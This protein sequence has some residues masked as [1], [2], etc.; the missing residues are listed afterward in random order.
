MRKK[1]VPRL[2][3][4]LFI[5]LFL[6][7]ETFADVNWLP[8]KE[9]DKVILIRHALAPGSGDPEGFNLKDCST[10]RN[11]DQVGIN[12][13]KKI[14][15]LFKKNNISIDQVLSSQWCR[16]KD[17]AKYAFK[18]YKEFSPLNST[19]QSPYKKKAEQQI[20]ELKN[21]VK[22]WNGNGK[23]LVLITHYIVITEVTDA[24]P[25]SGEIVITDKNFN[26]LTTIQTN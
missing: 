8:A 20:K 7:K 26:V 1:L 25:R 17:T 10:Q 23:N 4:L 18:K 11:L 21:F 15:Q 14:G 22:N 6:F 12:Q 3:F 13:S 5:S 24:V 16:C 9:G 19:F 2:I